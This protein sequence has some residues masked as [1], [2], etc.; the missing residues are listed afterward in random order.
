[1]QIKLMDEASL[2]MWA[3]LRSQLWPDHSSE[4]HLLDGQNILSCPDKYASFLAITNESRAMAFADAAVRHDYVNG[5]ES[6]PVV[7]LEGI[8]VLPEQRGRGVAKR[9]VT[10]VQDWGVTKGCTE[11]ASDASIDNPISCQ[12][13]QALGFEET[14]RVIFFRKRIDWP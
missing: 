3:E 9:L 2:N 1:M 4:D 10:A 8:F 12:M 5:C 6:S 14:D 11:M 7:Y 13:H